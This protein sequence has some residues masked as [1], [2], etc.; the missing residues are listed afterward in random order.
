MGD[1]LIDCEGTGRYIIFEKASGD[2][3]LPAKFGKITAFVEKSVGN[4]DTVT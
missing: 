3:C 2:C 4:L 1:G